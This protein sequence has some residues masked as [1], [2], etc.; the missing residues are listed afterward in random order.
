MSGRKP[1]V[2]LMCIVALLLQLGC[3][4][5]LDNAAIEQA[6]A[7]YNSDADYTEF[8]LFV[9]DSNQEPIDLS[10]TAVGRKV[11]EL[12]GVKLKT[13]YISGSDERTK[14]S[15]MV[16]TK[17]YP[18]LIAP[19]NEYATFRAADALVPLDDYI[20][21]YG[22]NIKRIYS[23]QELNMLRDPVDGHIYYLTPYRKN[24]RL[25]YPSSGFYLP[26]AVLRGLGW[27]KITSFDQY[28]EIIKNYVRANPVYNS[29]PTIGF[30]ALTDNWRI[31][32][33]F[34]APNYLAGNP[35]TG[36]VWVDENYEAHSFMLSDWAYK[37]YKKLNEFWNEG[38]LDK[39]MFTQNYDAY[40]AKIASGRV[41]GFYDERWQI[42]DAI[43]VLEKQSV[44]DRVPI[45]MPV[46][47]DGVDNEAYNG[48]SV[49]GTGAGVCI[50]R[51]CKDPET[52][53]KFIDKMASEEVLKVVYWGFEGV[54]Y[55]VQNGKFNLTEG[56]LRRIND[57]DYVHK[58]GLGSFWLFPHPD[59]GA[60]F[61]DGNYVF[62]QDTVEYMDYKYKDYEKEVLEAYKLTSMADLMAPPLET[63]YGFVWDI[64]I[65]DSEPE[66]KAA[67][68]KA[69]DIARKYIARLIM[70]TPEQYDLLWQ[71]Y[72]NKMK[73]AG[74]NMADE[75]LTEEIRR[76]IAE[77]NK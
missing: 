12:T 57:P 44:F 14:A 47:F 64:P 59:G 66:I 31:Y 7:Y 10:T 24:S 18:D 73:D 28:F 9:M 17:D 16:A 48:I 22:Q 19:H 72:A 39:D 4:N 50:T 76:R 15:F 68:Q 30:T 37:Y 26:I 43:D 13:E 20:D 58:R 6:D 54:D 21:K 29:E 53:F 62:P 25:L 40:K 2:V 45:A 51:N 77:R 69:S 41:I 27:P 42:E 38:L 61:S 5:S 32:T 71:E 65:P 34:N 36:G 3:S 52:A 49:M 11:S 56:Q 33:L 55:T 8:S 1:V 23:E 70:S 35:N 75:F 74:Y 63:P 67:N 60:K 46:V